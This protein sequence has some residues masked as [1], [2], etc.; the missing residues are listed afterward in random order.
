MKTLQQTLM[1]SDEIDLRK[2]FPVATESVTGLIEEKLK[3][4]TP[5]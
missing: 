5:Q 1:D 3:V 4:V 2:V